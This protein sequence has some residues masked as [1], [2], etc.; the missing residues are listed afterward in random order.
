MVLVWLHNVMKANDK[1]L[2]LK[3]QLEGGNKLLTDEPQE[4]VVQVYGM[5]QEETLITSPIA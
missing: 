5:I 3:Y 2:I 1:S 4:E